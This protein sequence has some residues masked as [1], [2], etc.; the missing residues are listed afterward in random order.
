MTSKTDLIKGSTEVI[1][2]SLLAD[3]N[4]YGYEIAQRIE[5]ESEGYLR[6]REGTLYPALKRLETQGLVESYWETSSEGPRRKYYKI[7]VTGHRALKDLS[8][9][10]SAFQKVMNRLVGDRHG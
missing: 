10:W 9:E 1:L 5:R 4:M 7:T 6:F 2:L 8:G 3:E